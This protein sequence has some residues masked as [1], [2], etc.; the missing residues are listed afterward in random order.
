MSRPY[1]IGADY[2]P[3]FTDFFAENKALRRACGEIG[4]LTLIDLSCK[5]Y[6]LG[7]YYPFV[8]RKQLC[9]DIAEDIAVDHIHRVSSR[10]D[11]AILYLVESCLIDKQLF[12][13]CVIT[14]KPF[15]K[16]YLDICRRRK[17]KPIIGN[18]WLLG[19][20]V[21]APKNPVNSEET[22]VNSEE[23]PVNSEESTLSKV[24]KIKD[25]TYT[26]ACVRARGV[27]SNV[28]LT[29]DEYEDIRNIIP[30]ADRY[31]NHFSERLFKGGYSIAD[32]HATILK[33]YEE[34]K[35]RF[36]ARYPPGD[37]G[38]FDTEEFFRL[39]L[40]RS[41]SG[42]N[43]DISTDSGEEEKHESELT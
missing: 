27:C 5:V 15:Q 4:L 41:Y 7:Y 29:D 13:K 17:T 3:F 30:D 38:S 8:D 28:F 19:G 24:N 40:A 39:A 25:H 23:T 12:D 10:V 16:Q 14:S 34:D 9:M 36:G 11:T 26:N 21:S 35:V 31:I 2:F 43:K 22:P 18:Y 37:S 42:M 20:V 32:H 6:G 33:W 1:K